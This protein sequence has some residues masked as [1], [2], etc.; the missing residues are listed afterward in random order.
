ML[1][2]VAGGGGRAFDGVEAIQFCSLQA[3]DG[4]EIEL[5]ATA[6]LFCERGEAGLRDAGEEVGSRA[7]G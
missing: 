2:L 3:G 1:G 5:A 7:T 4:I 6:V